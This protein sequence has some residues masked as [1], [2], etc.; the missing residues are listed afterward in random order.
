MN[1]QTYRLKHQTS[2]Q[3]WNNLALAH[4]SHP[5]VEQWRW[6][7][8][9]LSSIPTGSQDTD[10]LERSKDISTIAGILADMVDGAMAG[11]VIRQGRMFLLFRPERPKH[12]PIPTRRAYS[13][14]QELVGASERYDGV[15]SSCNRA[16]KGSLLCARA[17]GTPILPSRSY[18]YDHTSPARNSTPFDSVSLCFDITSKDSANIMKE[19]VDELA[20]ATWTCSWMILVFAIP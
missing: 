20:R 7:G 3:V 15:P 10:C 1:S 2:S 17:V 5:E 11:G 12:S 16:T 9:T 4:G 13:K 8:T 19:V 6:N 18:C 14:R